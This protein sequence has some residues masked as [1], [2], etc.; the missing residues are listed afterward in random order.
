LSLRATIL[1]LGLV[2]AASAAQAQDA[3]L[4][5][6][7]ALVPRL[8]QDTSSRHDGV[9]LLGV[10]HIVEDLRS[11]PDARLC[12][13]VS[14]YR[15]ATTHITWSATWDDVKHTAF[16]VNAHETSPSEAESRATTLRVRNHPPGLDG[17]FLLSAIVPYCEDAAFTKLVEN[18]LHTGIS[19]RD[20]FYRE[21]SY[22]VL[23]LTL[24][25]YGSGVV[26]NCLATVGNGAI[27]G[28][29]FIGTDWADASGRKFQLYVLSP[30]PEGFALKNRLWET[31][32]E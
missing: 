2:A 20:T 4:P 21:P 1:A 26:I 25:G 31:G 8:K 7:K 11:T 16:D 30:G 19:F 28:G 32:T 27:K 14:Q 29:I 10:D 15:D 3:V 5:S 23:G 13:G 22:N 12:T 18:E 24:N 17:T 9:P 6:C